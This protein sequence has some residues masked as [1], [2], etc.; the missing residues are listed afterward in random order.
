[1]KITVQLADSLGNTA[2]ATVT[3]TGNNTSGDGGVSD[4]GGPTVDAASDAMGDAGNTN[5]GASGGCGCTVI[6]EDP[7]TRGLLLLVA[8]AVL[9]LA[10]R[11]KRRDPGDDRVQRAE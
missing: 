11:R 8:A 9:S 6:G 3:V 5:P 4:G 2:T 10:R 7:S 1:M